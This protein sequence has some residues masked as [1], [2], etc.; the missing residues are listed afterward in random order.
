MPRHSAVERLEAWNW[1]VCVFW[2]RYEEVVAVI[3]GL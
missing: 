2:Q 3:F 1:F